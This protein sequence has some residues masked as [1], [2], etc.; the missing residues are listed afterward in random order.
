[1]CYIY[2]HLHFHGHLRKQAEAEAAA[3]A[4]EGAAV[5]ARASSVYPNCKVTYVPGTNPPMYD[6]FVGD[7]VFSIKVVNNLV[8]RGRVRTMKFQGNTTLNT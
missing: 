7:G 3:A 6:V 5:A 8:P 2:V 1:M 4:A